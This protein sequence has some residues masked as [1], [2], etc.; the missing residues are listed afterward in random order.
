VP[1]YVEP[2]TAREREELAATL[3]Q[4]ADVHPRGDESMIEVGGDELTP[5]DLATAVNEPGSPAGR[6]ALRVYAVALRGDDRNEIDFERLMSAYRRD[7]EL[8]ASGDFR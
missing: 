5:R 7:T 8:W 6:L 2:L 1:R 3:A 4:W